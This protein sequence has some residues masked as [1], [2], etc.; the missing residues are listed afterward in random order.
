MAVEDALEQHVLDLVAQHRA[1]HGHGVGSRVRGAV[2][3]CMRSAG[4]IMYSRAGRIIDY[5][6]NRATARAGRAKE[7][8]HAGQSDREVRMM[9]ALVVAAPD[10]FAV[11]DVDRPSP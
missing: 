4:S 6:R 7:E 3:S 2:R 10:D 5:V 1:V 11:R 9:R 8:G